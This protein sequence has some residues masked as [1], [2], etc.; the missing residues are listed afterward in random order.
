LLAVANCKEKAAPQPAAAA[1]EKWDCNFVGTQKPAQGDVGKFSWKVLWTISGN[2]STITGNSTDEAGKS[3]ANG[4][5]EGNLCK[6]KEVYS[7]GELKGR[8]YDWTFTYEDAETK[9]EAVYITTLKGTFASDKDKA[10]TGTLTAKS[11]CKF[12]P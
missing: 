4:T 2:A 6:I 11:D 1:G 8:V 7:T 5:C 10:D 9:N 12:V 3:T